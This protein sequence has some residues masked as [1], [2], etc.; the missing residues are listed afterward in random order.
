MKS[1]VANWKEENRIVSEHIRTLDS[2]NS[3]LFLIHWFSVLR[4][5]QFA[6]Q[7]YALNVI[8]INSDPDGFNKEFAAK[9][10]VGK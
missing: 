2:R 10:E 7:K 4:P 3:K 1:E 6:D 9:N 8:A 5:M